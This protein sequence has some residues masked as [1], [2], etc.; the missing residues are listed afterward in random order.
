MARVI[1]SR[2]QLSGTLVTLSPLHIGG[3]GNDPTVDLTL[4]V[5]G[6]G[7]YYIPGTSLAGAIRA[8]LKDD[9]NLWGSQD[10]ASYVIVE[11]SSLPLIAEIRSGVSLDRHWGTAAEQLLYDRAVIPK[12]TAFDLHLTVEIP[13]GSNLAEQ[14]ARTAVETL[15]TALT[16]GDIRFGAAKTRGLG[17]VKLGEDYIYRQQQLLTFEGILSA[18]E[19]DGNRLPKPKNCS[20][21]KQQQL[22]ITINWKP[23]APLMVKASQEGLQVNILPLVSAV[24]N[25]MAMVLPG[26]SIKGALRF[27]AERIIRT[28]CQIAEIKDKVLEAENSNDIKQ[29]IKQKLTKQIELPL[30][31]ALFGIAAK[32]KS[33][34]NLIKTDE[35]TNQPLLGLGAFAVEDCYT[36]QRFTPS[37]WQD[38]EQATTSLELQNALAAA[39]L[40]STQEAFHVAVD[41]WTGGAAK[42]FLYSNLEPFGV[43]WEPLQ[44]TLNLKRIPEN[45]KLCAIALLILT[46]RDLSQHRIPL[47]YGVNRGMGD[48]AVNE[49]SISGRGLPD[50][51]ESL[52]CAKLSFTA[53]GQVLGLDEILLTKL[54]QYW[55]SWIE[56]NQYLEGGE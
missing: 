16:A 25:E 12:G 28:V 18:L 44:L 43:E 34:N 40:D 2:L 36:K 41:R 37:Q 7:Q 52:T 23:T 17:R 32:I 29:H 54:N 6:Q 33:Q 13:H 19:K 50:L 8:S 15:I 24:G 14:Q 30:I 26:S 51:L 39:H 38:I 55:R 48:L 3:I 1:A 10:Q 20:L 31:S 27:H 4:A 35:F 45:E 56:C 11:D 21:I 46:L 53:E 9:E 42:G 5:N 49:I 47:G 22:H